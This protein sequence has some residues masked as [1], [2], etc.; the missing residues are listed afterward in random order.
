MT[1]RIGTPPVERDRAL[2]LLQRVTVGAAVAGVAATAGFGVLAALTDA[3]QPAT[4][5]TAGT[6]STDPPDSTQQP[7]ALP[8]NPNDNGSGGQ[9]AP[10]PTLPRSPGFGGG[11]VTTGGSR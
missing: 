3:G 5:T 10:A 11:H 9:L 8:D 1:N 4:T 2:G 7:G 6:S